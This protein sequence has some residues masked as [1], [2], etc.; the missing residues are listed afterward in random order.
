MTAKEYLLQAK[1]IITR[2]EAMAEQLEFLRSAAVYIVPQWSD[3][4]KAATRNVHK[5]EDAIVRV[6]EFEDRMKAQYAKLTEINDTVDRLR[7]PMHRIILV[8]RYFSGKTWREV[9]CE[10]HY[11]ERMVRRIYNDALLEI[12]RLLESC[13]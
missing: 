11:N 9:A 10:I 6:M 13:S 2:L 8:K 12:D 1:S 5:N 3:L 7:D 4:P